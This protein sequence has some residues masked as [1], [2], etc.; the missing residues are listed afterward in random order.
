MRSSFFSLESLRYIFQYKYPTSIP[1]SPMLFP[2]SGTSAFSKARLVILYNLAAFR[3]L[4][5]YCAIT[6]SL[7]DSNIVPACDIFK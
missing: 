7:Y 3:Y 5:S 2:Q 6:A 1:V 4:F